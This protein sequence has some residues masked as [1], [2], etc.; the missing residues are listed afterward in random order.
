MLIPIAETTDLLS[1]PVLYSLRKNPFCSLHLFNVQYLVVI[2]WVCILNGLCG[3][4]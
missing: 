1:T 2:Q 3:S 4:V